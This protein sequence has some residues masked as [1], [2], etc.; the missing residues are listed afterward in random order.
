MTLQPA[1]Q[2]AQSPPALRISQLHVHQVIISL[3]VVMHGAFL[4]QNPLWTSYL[5][6]GLL[7]RRYICESQTL[8]LLPLTLAHAVNKVV[9]ALAKSGNLHAPAVP[10]SQ[11][12]PAPEVRLRKCDGKEHASVCENPAQIVTPAVSALATLLS[13]TTSAKVS[14]HRGY[15]PRLTRLQ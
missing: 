8:S 11:E 12:E 15:L 5:F 1:V 7:S 4:D 3:H 10:G 14:S 13:S 6:S 2:K 9:E